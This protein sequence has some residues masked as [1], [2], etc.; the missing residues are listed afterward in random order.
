[1]A[2]WDCAID[3]FAMAE[4]PEAFFNLGNAYAQRGDLEL[5]LSAFDE[6]LEMRPAWVEAQENRTLVASLI[7]PSP[8]EPEGGQE[9]ASDPNLPPE[10]VRFDEKGNKGKRGEID[11]SLLTEDQMGEIWLRGL[12]TSPA[13]FLA[14]K[15]AVQAAEQQAQAK[16]GDR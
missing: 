5:A 12:S 4:T 8:A 15:F 13:R 1:V 6:A 11:R 14:Q 7:P 2:D 16:E 9:E 10:E 3:A